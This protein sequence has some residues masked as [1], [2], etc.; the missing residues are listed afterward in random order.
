MTDSMHRPGLLSPDELADLRREMTE[1]FAWMTSELARRRNGEINEGLLASI[2]E[3]AG[4]RPGC[5]YVPTQSGL[6]GSHVKTSP[7]TDTLD[8]R[9]EYKPLKR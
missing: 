5:D 8:A 9:G 6:I 3:L 4:L 1:S 7:D 2:D